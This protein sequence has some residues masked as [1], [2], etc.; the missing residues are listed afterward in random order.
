MALSD[1]RYYSGH[2]EIETLNNNI[3]AQNIEKLLCGIFNSAV[4]EISGIW[5]EEIHEQFSAPDLEHRLT[6]IE[7]EIN[8]IWLEC[9]T[10]P[11]VLQKFKSIMNDWI[12]LYKQ[13]ISELKKLDEK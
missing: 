11:L 1:L 3:H 6:E 10:N 7:E 12:I 2:S 5:K 4:D 13:I 8:R 9:R